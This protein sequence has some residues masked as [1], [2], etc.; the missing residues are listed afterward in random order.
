[1]FTK[2]NCMYCQ[3]PIE[4]NLA[5]FIPSGESP[6]ERLGQKVPCPHCSK[7]TV[8]SIKKENIRLPNRPFIHPADAAAAKKNRGLKIALA[9]LAAI[10]VLT[11]LIVAIYENEVSAG[12]IAGAG[13]NLVVVIIGAVIAILA[14]TLAIF[15]LVFPWLMYSQSNQIL[16]VLKQIEINTRPE[17]KP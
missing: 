2:C 15:W 8:L 3:G 9:I 16:D 11:A 10:I 4:F 12:Q 7:E 17:E 1:M 5:D 13:L 6:S 14:F